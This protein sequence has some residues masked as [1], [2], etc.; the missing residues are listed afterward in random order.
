[1]KNNSE[2]KLST[3]DKYYLAV[4][5][6]IKS[7]NNYFNEIKYH[8]FNLVQIIDLYFQLVRKSDNKAVGTFSFIYEEN[9][10]FSPLRGTFGGPYISKENLNF[11]ILEEF[12]FK[13]IEILFENEP[14]SIHIKLSAMSNNMNINSIEQSKIN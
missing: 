2:I 5:K 9:S 12:I 10:F 3:S 8:K 14:N 4:N 6:F 13:I 11:D 7:E 1:M